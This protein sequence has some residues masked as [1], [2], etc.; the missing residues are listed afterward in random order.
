M[1]GDKKHRSARLACTLILAVSTIAQARIIHVDDNA[2][3]GGDGTSWATAY[4]FLQDGLAEAMAGDEIRVG[5]GVYKPDRSSAWPQGSGDRAASFVLPEGVTVRGGYA[6]MDATE[7][8][9]WEADLYESVLSG[10]LAGDDVEDAPAL[11][12]HEE[13][14]WNNSLNVVVAGSEAVLEGVTVTGGFAWP[15]RCTP[16]YCPDQWPLDEHIGGGA[17]IKADGVVL[18]ECLFVGNFAE[19]GGG[20]LF[21]HQSESVLLESCAFHGNAATTGGGGAFTN[22]SEAQIQGCRFSENWTSVSGGGLCS[23]NSD[24]IVSDC[25]LASNQ[26]ANGGG[27]E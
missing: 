12:M 20:G 26:A 22:H 6:G 8:N 25:L 13:A 3:P 27:D 1:S 4:R 2:P 14:R 15:G 10:D 5:Q 21:I 24:L 18:R 23:E 16:P 17:L 7:P 19:Q 9:A 11:L